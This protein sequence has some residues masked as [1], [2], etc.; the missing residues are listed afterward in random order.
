MRFPRRA[1]IGGAALAAIACAV[2]ACLAAVAF[3]QTPPE[4]EPPRKQLRGIDVSRFQ[5]V[6]NWERVGK[7]KNSFVWAQASRG[8]G[9]D[10]A[11]APTECG[12]DA[13]YLR[14]YVGASRNGLRVGAYHRAFAS[15]KTRRKA[16]ADAR[17]E[18]RVFTKAA[19]EI[20]RGDLRPVLDVESPFINL[21]KS[22]LK[23]WIKTW[24]RGVQ[25]RTGVRPMIYTNNSSW[26]A[27]GDTQRFALKGYKLWV[28][29]F[30]VDSPLVPA[31]DWA[32]RSWA[33][34]QF[35]STGSV[36]GIEGNVD[37]NRLAVPLSKITA[38]PRH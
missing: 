21:T 29:N 26:Q 30:G 14:N 13:F 33:V 28:A 7:T 16:R 34:W 24:M 22:R 18:A 38:R 3:A 11:V 31:G 9:S 19:G 6:I 35:T 37:K 2:F 36:R 27:T 15:G 17:A 10:C 5:G 8:S 23:L 25:R 12:R 32:G 4:P 20:Q 1:G